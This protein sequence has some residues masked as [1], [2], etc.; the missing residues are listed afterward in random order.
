MTAAPKAHVLV[1]DD[2]PDVR[3]FLALWLIG[4]GCQVRTVENGEG[5]QRALAE[6]IPDVILLDV[7]LPGMNG[8]E[9]CLR[10]KQQAPT[11]DVPIVMM[12]G[13]REPA[14]ALRAREL[15]AKHYLQ[16]PFDESELTSVISSVVSR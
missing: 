16:K 3:M 12:S 5:A 14:N 9:V 11:R 4:F 7:V 8:F 10:L 2:S 1:V 13:L 15:G 6:R